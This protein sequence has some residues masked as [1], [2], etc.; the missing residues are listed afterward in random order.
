MYKKIKEQIGKRYLTLKENNFF[1]N[2]LVVFLLGMYC[3]KVLA[4]NAET[5]ETT[6]DII[7]VVIINIILFFIWFYVAIILSKIVKKYNN[8]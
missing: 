6:T 8:K 2:K 4:N 5:T 3:S 7:I 1:A